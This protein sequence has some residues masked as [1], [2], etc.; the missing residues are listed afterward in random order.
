MAPTR[1]AR[2]I[3]G[4]IITDNAPRS[5]T[6]NVETDLLLWQLDRGVFHDIFSHHPEMPRR[7]ATGW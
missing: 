5:A 6:A 4:E 7:F 1:F 2:R 3:P